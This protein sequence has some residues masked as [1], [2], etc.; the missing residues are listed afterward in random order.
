MQKEEECLPKE[1]LEEVG[2]A[3]TIELIEVNL[4]E[5]ITDK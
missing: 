2:S 4:S 1:K 5:K 3:P